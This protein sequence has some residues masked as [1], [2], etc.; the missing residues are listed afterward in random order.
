MGLLSS[1]DSD[2]VIVD[3]FEGF[4]NSKLIRVIDTQTGVVCYWPLHHEGFEAIPISETELDFEDLDA[5]E[6]PE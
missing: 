4:K 5:L 6:D 3:S 1:D 2:E